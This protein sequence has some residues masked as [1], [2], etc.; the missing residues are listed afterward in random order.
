MRRDPV[1]LIMLALK[2]VSWE[3]GQAGYRAIHH[4]LVVK[5]DDPT[6]V[7][8]GPQMYLAVATDW[9]HDGRQLLVLDD[10]SRMPAVEIVMRNLVGDDAWF[11]VPQVDAWEVTLQLLCAI[12]LRA[13]G[14][15]ATGWPETTAIRTESSL[16]GVLELGHRFMQAQRP[17]I[18][19]TFWQRAADG[20]LTPVDM[21]D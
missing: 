1:A 2:L 10:G 12:D 8:V 17:E 21:L 16:P 9:S 19:V 7:R 3:S 18:P 6:P 15:N 13:E 14:M 11:A 4:T 5:L 20:A